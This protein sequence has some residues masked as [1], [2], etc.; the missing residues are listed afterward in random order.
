MRILVQALASIPLEGGVCLIVQRAEISAADAVSS[1]SIILGGNTANSMS[2]LS[3][4]ARTNVELAAEGR[5]SSEAQ[6]AH[7]ILVMVDELSFIGTRLLS[8]IQICMQ[9]R[10]REEHSE[11]HKNDHC[12]KCSCMMF[13]D[14][15]QLGC[16]DD[17]RLVPYD[18]CR[19]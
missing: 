7:V 12:G 11:D 2:S 3:I 13:G 17:L 14:F 8:Q 15:G 10:T 16:I 6:G 18:A 5:N 4:N 19:C 9:Q 1:F